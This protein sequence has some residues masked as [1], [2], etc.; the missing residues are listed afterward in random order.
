M[1]VS[2]NGEPKSGWFLTRSGEYKGWFGITPILRSTQK[3]GAWHFHLQWCCRSLRLF[4]VNF[5]DSCTHAEKWIASFRVTASLTVGSMRVADTVPGTQ[6]CSHVFVVCA[7]LCWLN[8]VFLYCCNSLHGSFVLTIC[9]GRSKFITVITS[10]YLLLNHEPF[11]SWKK[12]AAV[13]W[14]KSEVTAGHR[15]R[16]WF[17]NSW[18]S[19]VSHWSDTSTPTFDQAPQKAFPFWWTSCNL[20]CFCFF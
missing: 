15:N 18:I 11:N 5:D 6:E 1:V 13:Q 9:N 8:D 20:L 17:L 12:I 19:L 14:R 7:H 4:V 10:P 3:A 16:W 2:H